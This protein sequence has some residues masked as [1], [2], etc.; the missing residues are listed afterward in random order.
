M[1]TIPEIEEAIGCLSTAVPEFFQTEI[2]RLTDEIVSNLKSVID[3]ISVLK[4]LSVGQVA[5]AADALAE[6]TVYDN[7]GQAIAGLARRV[8]EREADDLLQVLQDRF[9]DAVTTAEKLLNIQEKVVSLVYIFMGFYSETPYFGAQRICAVIERLNEVKK[10]N[11][12]C[13][14]KHIR[15]SVNMLLLV[16][17]DD[18]YRDDTLADL[19]V[20]SSLMGEAKL[21][22]LRS[23][24]VASGVTGYDQ[25]AFSRA[26]ES[27]L[28]ADEILA[29][30]DGDVNILDILE[31]LDTG[32]LNSTIATLSNIKT[33]NLTM[34][35]LLLAMEAE[36]VA[37]SSQVNVINFYVNTFTRIL[38]SYA[39]SANTQNVRAMRSR[40]IFDIADRVDSMKASIDV[41]RS[42]EDIAS[43]QLEMFGWSSR[44]KSIVSM[45]D[46]TGRI[47]FEAGS[48]VGGG[49]AAQLASNYQ[50]TVDAIAAINIGGTVAGVEDISLVVNQASGIVA[51]VRR[52]MNQLSDG[53]RDEAALR[54]LHGLA[55]KSANE[56]IGSIED[57]LSAADQLT[58]ACAIMVNADISTRARYDDLIHLMDEVGFDRGADFLRSGQYVDVVSS[59]FEGLSYTGT[60]VACL[61]DAIDGVDNTQQRRQLIEIRDE[62]IAQQT[63]QQLAA[64]TGGELQVVQ[65][66]RRIQDEIERWEQRSASVLAIAESLKEIGETIGANVSQ[67]IEA[68]KEMAANLDHIN[69]GA[70][71]RLSDGLREFSKNPRS[72]VP[73]C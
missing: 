9:P 34:P 69:V 37:I 71:G 31:V 45:I 65:S 10:R 70:A 23:Q 24:P 49:E 25:N 72:G 56:Q 6:K 66:I 13:L 11:L 18:T 55:V 33:T 27:L 47:A 3:P 29:P 64:R 44:V 4:D 42:R 59:T 16:I 2:A 5:E 53:I 68:A 7:V 14:Q 35:A 61:K 17:E 73:F 8:L 22:L 38:S 20:L 63:N 39:A 28:E 54:T 58:S 57:S 51:L 62:I 12:E 41:A 67:S 36:I 21:E 40:L 52:I 1:A 32:A 30:L 26:R 43:A 19:D 15:Q 60:A 48:S 46:E 50:S